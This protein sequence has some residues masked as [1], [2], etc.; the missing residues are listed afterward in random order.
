MTQAAAPVVSAAEARVWPKSPAAGQTYEISPSVHTLS[1]PGASST[2]AFQQ[3]AGQI[4]QRHL[5]LGRR[6]FALCGASSGAGVTF[7]A[8][9]LAVALSR[10]GVQTLLIDAN[11]R[12]PALDA[13]I[14]PN[15]TGPGLRQVSE[16]GVEALEAIH[17][18]VT[19]N[20][21]LMFAGGASPNASDLLSGDR[22]HKLL[23]ACLRDY[24]CVIVDTP[25]ANRS[26]DAINIA[27]VI[28][29]AIIVG[30]KRHSYVDDAEM[31][32]HQLTQAGVEIVGAVFNG[33]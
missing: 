31:L 3:I 15:E 18:S 4:I 32:A 28:G 19:E 2:L 23:G 5:S 25:A 20:L 24:E 29:Y 11:L 7:A 8:V 27:A 30:R 9:N 12:R 16:G 14:R 10:T 1:Q 6:G 26:A 33:G 13:Y 17:A 22:A 21:S